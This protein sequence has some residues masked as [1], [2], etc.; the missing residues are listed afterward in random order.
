LLLDQSLADAA[1]TMQARRDWRHISQSANF[2]LVP[3][4]C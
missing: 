1:R 2:S 4:I 3:T